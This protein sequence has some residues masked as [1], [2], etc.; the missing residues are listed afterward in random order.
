MT[1][2]EIVHSQYGWF[3]YSIDLVS[4]SLLHLQSIKHSH[5][6]C[7]PRFIHPEVRKL[8]YINLPSEKK[9]WSVIKA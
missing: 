6:V 3:A 9:K 5:N 7:I 8:F 2:N 1:A 4:G